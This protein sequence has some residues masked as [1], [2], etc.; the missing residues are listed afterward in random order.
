MDKSKYTAE[1]VKSKA[2]L[3]FA[4]AKRARSLEDM[5]KKISELIGQLEFDTFYD[6]GHFDEGSIIRVRDCA[7]ALRG[8][9]KKRSDDHAKFSVAKALRDVTNNKPRHDLSPAFWAEMYHI[10]TGIQG[11]GPGASPERQF[12]QTTDL[13][14][15]EAAI[16]RS[17]DLDQLWTRKV[18]TGLEHF[19]SGLDPDI[20]KLRKQRREHILSELGASPEDWMDPIWQMKNVVRRLD[21]LEKLVKLS[22]DEKKAVRQAQE[23]KLPFGITPY[24][25]SL[26]DDEPGKHDRAIRAQVI[27]PLS[28]VNL[29]GKSRGLDQSLFDF[30]HEHDTSPIDLITRRYPGIAIF[31]PFNTCPQICVYCQRNWEIDQPMAPEAMADKKTREAALAWVAKQPA[32]HEL[33]VTGG[34]PLA[35][36]EKDIKS[37][38]DQVAQIDTIDFI[39]IG[40][41]TPVTVP[42]RITDSLADY[43][44]GLRVPGRRQVS[45]V[46]HIQHPSEIT[47]ETMDAVEK[48]KVRGLPVYNQLVYTFY[49]SRRFEAAAL[50]NQLRLIG[51]DPYY[52]FATKGKEETLEYRVPMARLL[53][54]QKEEARLMPGLTRTDEAV[55]NVPGLGKNYLR[56][57]QQRDLISILP[58]GARVYEFHP[59]EK[60]ISSQLHTYAGEDVP[61]LDYLERLEVLGEEVSDYNTIWYYY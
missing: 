60:N 4:A 30:M 3:F 51:I 10:L 50:R 15:R 49:I 45:V 43:L 16:M 58:S 48:L 11:M 22:D 26:M 36:P 21:K 57:S 40:T 18:K 56:A 52:T 38:F 29:M 7:G 46:T 9:L 44:A 5:R 12:L 13:E 37:V 17:K 32:L 61:I 8:M 24:Y 33:L 41:R 6:Y 31:K 1:A 34:D 42:M 39:R 35:M 28:Y 54:E 14:G 25:L 53:Q 19:K 55:Y 59:W 23:C 2:P 47:P 20:I 27:P